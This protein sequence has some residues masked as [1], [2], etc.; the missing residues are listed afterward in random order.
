MTKAPALEIFI[1][2]E[3]RVG[4][5]SRPKVGLGKYLAVLEGLSRE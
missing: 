5:V 4:A 1:V 3:F 2:A